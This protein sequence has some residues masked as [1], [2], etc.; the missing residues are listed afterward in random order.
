MCMA[1]HAKKSGLFRLGEKNK[2]EYVQRFQGILI[3]KAKGSP[4]FYSEGKPTGP[5][6]IKKPTRSK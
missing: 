6:S 1:F 5:T 3:L 2:I 4:H